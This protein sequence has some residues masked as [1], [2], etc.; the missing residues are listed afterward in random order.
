MSERKGARGGGGGENA[1]G[2]MTKISRA[3]LLLL[4]CTS[5]NP[6]RTSE[7]GF[8]WYPGGFRMPQFHSFIFSVPSPPPFL[9]CLSCLLYCSVLICTDI[10]VSVLPTSVMADWCRLGMQGTAG[11]DC[12]SYLIK[13]WEDPTGA[14]A[15]EDTGTIYRV[16]HRCT[17]TFTSRESKEYRC[18][19]LSL[20][21][22]LFLTYA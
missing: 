2:R 18:F 12:S 19:P 8:L 20:D 5:G 16:E 4:V 11:P 22:M 6:S 17:Q 3:P 7:Q 21:T 10:P 15:R 14:R 1:E 9:F 13:T